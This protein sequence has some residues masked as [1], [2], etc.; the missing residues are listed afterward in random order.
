MTA[1]LTVGA[2]PSPDNFEWPGDPALPAGCEIQW[3][4]QQDSE[5]HID[6][7]CHLWTGEVILNSGSGASGPFFVHDRAARAWAFATALNS[8]ERE[9]CQLQVVPYVCIRR[10]A[11]N[12]ISRGETEFKRLNKFWISPLRSGRRVVSFTLPRPAYSG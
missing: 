5:L 12:L 3:Q 8:S 6:A 10:F 2:V 1:F 9:I 7:A 4:E 11:P